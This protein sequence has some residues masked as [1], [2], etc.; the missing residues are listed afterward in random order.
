MHS[1]FE[2]PEQEQ[3][4][5]ILA[6]VQ[7]PQVNILAHPTGRIINRRD[8]FAFDLDAVLEA[9]AENRVAVELNAH[10]SRLDLKDTH[11]M[12]AKEKGAKVVISTDAHRVQDLALMSYGVE[13][14][15][16]AWLEAGDVINCWSLEELLGFLRK[17]G[18]VRALCELLFASLIKVRSGR[19]PP[20]PTQQDRSTSFHTDRLRSRQFDTWLTALLT[21]RFRE[22]DPE[23]VNRGEDWWGRTGRVH[24]AR[25]F[26]F[27]GGP[28]FRRAGRSRC[29]WRPGSGT[30]GTLK[31]QSSRVYGRWGSGSGCIATR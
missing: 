25:R 31:G 10:P 30:G 27:S 3:T 17:L 19:A 7:H 16:R 5:R 20:P 21:V 18:V 6:A 11:L 13:Q 4:A 8:P 15:R 2:L 14:G 23:G 29:G 9:C 12:R 24:L 22:R 1:R 28:R 26:G